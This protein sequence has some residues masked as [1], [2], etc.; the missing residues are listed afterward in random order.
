LA[1]DNKRF[2][3][4]WQILCFLEEITIRDINAYWNDTHN[5]EL[6]AFREIDSIEINYPSSKL[7]I[8]S[9]EIKRSFITLRSIKGFISLLIDSKR[10]NKN[11]AQKVASIDEFYSLFD[12]D[13]VLNILFSAEEYEKCAEYYTMNISEFKEQSHVQ[14]L[15]QCC[16]SKLGNYISTVAISKKDTDSLLSTMR[17]LWQ[18]GNFREAWETA[19][20][21]EPMLPNS[22][23]VQRRKVSL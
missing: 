23:A 21:L 5:I 22:D 19:K 17:H 15:Y 9:K 16:L 14:S 10:L 18:K 13:E 6:L 11:I 7:M 2:N 1:L 20:I 3:E 4:L 12:T 8:S